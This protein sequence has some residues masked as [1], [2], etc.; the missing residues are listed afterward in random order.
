MN[1]AS[2]TC[3]P[4]EISNNPLYVADNVIRYYQERTLSVF[5][6]DYNSCNNTNISLNFIQI[7]GGIGELTMTPDGNVFKSYNPKIGDQDA[8]PSSG[9]GCKS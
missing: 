8:K 9:C 3:V 4:R 2:L 6:S 7:K 1:I 5:L